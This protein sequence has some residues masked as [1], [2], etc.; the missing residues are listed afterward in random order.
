MKDTVVESRSEL[1]QDPTRTMYSGLQDAYDYMNEHLFEPAFGRR[2]PNCLLTLRATG[3]TFGYFSADRFVGDDGK[4]THEIA[5]N[6]ASFACRSVE[7][8]LSTMAHEMCHLLQHVDGSAGRSTY[9]NTEFSNRMDKIGLITSDTGKPGGKR[10]AQQMSHY[11]NTDGEFIRIIRPF[12]A[13]GYRAR[14]ADRFTGALRD[15]WEPDHPPLTPGGTSLLDPTIEVEPIDGQPDPEARQG[16]LSAPGRPA[17]ARAATPASA[18]AGDLSVDSADDDD[19]PAD[20]NALMSSLPQDEDAG[21][22]HAIAAPVHKPM[23]EPLASRVQGVFVHGRHGR[24]KGAT[25]H[26][27][28]CPQCSVAVWGKPSLNIKCGN[29]DLALEDQG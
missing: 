3:K 20:M 14:W 16:G 23:E 25:R 11:I 21:E 9:H 1:L 12:L 6:P 4:L 5:L 2:L 19:Q 18:V 7:L 13:E 29:C 27:Y 17:A 22:A 28:G 26:K 24:T 10:V 15:E 8:S